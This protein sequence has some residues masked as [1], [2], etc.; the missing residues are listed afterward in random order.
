[1]N[2][3]DGQGTLCNPVP[4]RVDGYSYRTLGNCTS[5]RVVSDVDGY[6]SQAEPGGRQRFRVSDASHD[7][8][9]RGYGITD[10]CG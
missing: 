4:D 8:G 3:P 7:G 1:M 6:V 2:V 5:P 10:G 9:C